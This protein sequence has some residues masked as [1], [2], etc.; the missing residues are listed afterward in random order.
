MLTPLAILLVVLGTLVILASNALGTG[1]FLRK[2]P[3][4]EYAVGLI[5]HFTLLLK[6]SGLVV[7]GGVLASLQSGS[8]ISGFVQ[9]PGW[10]KGVITVIVSIGVAL[11]AFMAFLAWCQ[12]GS[13]GVKTRL[14]AFVLCWLVGIVGPI[15]LATVLVVD[16]SVPQQAFR[17]DPTLSS[18]TRAACWTLAGFAG[19]GYL[20]GSLA[21]GSRV[22]YMYGRAKNWARSLA[23]FVTRLLMPRGVVLQEL[24]KELDSHPA[25][26]PLSDT[27]SYF[28][29]PMV[30]RDSACRALLTQRVL[31]YP[32]VDGE[33]CTVMRAGSL[34]DRWS[35]F[36]FVRTASP[37]LLKVHEAA[38]SEAVRIGILQTA[39]DMDKTPM[40]LLD[41][42]LKR[43]P[44][45][46]VKSLIGAA[47]RF[48]G[49]THYERLADA[50]TQ[51]AHGAE[52]LRAD[53]RKAKVSKILKR[54][55]YPI[56][57]P[58][59]PSLQ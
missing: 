19:L 26:A 41:F 29:H 39:E 51:L 25:N 7:L 47:G 35:G 45:A 57:N 36:E 10:A 58:Q 2:P 9:T 34:R 54:A 59:Q 3:R 56:P 42:H 44:P 53:K 30:K 5:V 40:L 21:F 55:G 23:P 33:L 50:L 6:G 52:G 37:E 31:A 18:A 11:A 8:V 46:F 48:R 20:A 17:D 28:T 49:T 15:L 32:G 13:S 22:K 27:L 43:N 1:F 16:V 12:S 14:T 24:R 4:G 38:W